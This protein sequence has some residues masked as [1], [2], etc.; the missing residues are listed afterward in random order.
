MIRTRLTTILVLLLLVIPL[1]ACTEVSAPAQQPQPAPPGSTTPIANSGST[2]PRTQALTA[3][4]VAGKPNRTLAFKPPTGYSV[5][6][7]APSGMI[8]LSCLIGKQT[9]DNNPGICMIDPTSATDTVLV[10]PNLKKSRIAPGY[11]DAGWLVYGLLDAP[12]RIMALNTRTNEEVEVGRISAGAT[13]NL[14]GLV[15]AISGSRI[16]WV[17]SQ[18]ERGKQTETVMLFDL[19]GR[20]NQALATVEAPLLIDQIAISG[21]NVVWSQVDTSNEKDVHS[22]VYLYRVSTGEHQALSH[23][24]RASM[25]GIAGQHVVWKTTASRFAYGSIYL[26]DLETNTGKEIASANPNLQPVQQ[27]YDAPSIGDRGVTWLSSTNDKIELYRLEDGS[28]QVL[29]QGGGKAYTAGHYVV[30]VN[31]SVTKKGDW[32]LLWSDLSADDSGS[33]PPPSAGAGSTQVPAPSAPPPSAG[34]GSTQVPAPS[35]PP[36]T[37]APPAPTAAPTAAPPAPEQGFQT[38]TDPTNTYR[39]QYPSGS[40]ITAQPE[41]SQVTLVLTR[42]QTVYTVT[43]GGPVAVPAGAEHPEQLLETFDQNIGSTSTKPQSLALK[44]LEAA[45]VDTT[46]QPG[47]Q[48][49][50]TVHE[51]NVAAFSHGMLYTFRFQVSGPDQCDASAVPLFEQMLEGFELIGGP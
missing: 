29:D 8:F 51:R 32:H 41:I 45:F 37:A 27:A 16:V 38:Y 50:P 11:S 19:S 36:P 10:D 4:P 3:I 43:I 47:T 39:L 31:D 24:G 15:Y 21:D 48:P 6:T 14:V 12:Q 26:Y 22:D 1:S 34:A 42:E 23:D 17:D 25:P 33:A 9:A 35:A 20:K 46:S 30:W 40:V 5:L 18:G 7:V 13:D 44:G 28:T 49:C 2:P